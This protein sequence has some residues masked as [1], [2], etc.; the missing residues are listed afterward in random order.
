M[1]RRPISHAVKTQLPAVMQAVQRT[2]L[3][4]TLPRTPQDP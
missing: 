2:L 1:T 4:V 3:S